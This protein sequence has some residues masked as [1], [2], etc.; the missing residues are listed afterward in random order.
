MKEFEP[1]KRLKEVLHAKRN[2]EILASQ[3][4]INRY[5]E[6]E[7]DPPGIDFVSYFPDGN[8]TEIVSFV[9]KV[10]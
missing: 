8:D 9:P 5:Y 10:R 2:K 4:R 1:I 7:Q 6:A 3:E